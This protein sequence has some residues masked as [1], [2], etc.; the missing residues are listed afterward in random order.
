MGK[1]QRVEEEVDDNDGEREDDE[2]EEEEEKLAPGDQE[3]RVLDEDE[4]D[5]DEADEDEAEP[6]DKADDD[7]ERV[8]E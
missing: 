1:A 6:F 3:S 4:V 5:E 7:D 8:S 2:G